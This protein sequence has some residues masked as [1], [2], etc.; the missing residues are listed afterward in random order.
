MG[1]ILHTQSGWLLNA[2]VKWNQTNWWN[3][4]RIK[5]K[6]FI[7]GN[8]AQ[9]AH[10]FPLANKLVMTT[11]MMYYGSELRHIQRANDVTR[12]RRAAVARGRRPHDRHLESM[13]SYKNPIS[14]RIYLKNNSI[15]FH[16]DPLWNEW[17]LGFLKTIP[18]LG[19]RR[20]TARRLAIWDPPDRT[21]KVS[22]L[23]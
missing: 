2:T 1:C 22:G 19:R 20:T 5:T 16:S 23:D 18:P 4:Y 11:S 17:A 10:R 7:S 8:M 21:T 14:M 15:N 12:A 9:Y 13:T 3:Q 6:A